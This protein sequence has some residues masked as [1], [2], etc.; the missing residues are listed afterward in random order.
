[1]F[2]TVNSLVLRSFSC[3]PF[4][5]TACRSVCVSINSKIN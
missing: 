5:D 1:M 4:P 2:K 3:L